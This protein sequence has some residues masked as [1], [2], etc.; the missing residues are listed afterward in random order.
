MRSSWTL[1]ADSGGGT[2]CAGFWQTIRKPWN[3]LN[4]REICVYS[5]LKRISNCMFRNLRA[6]SFMHIQS[7]RYSAD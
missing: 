1:L 5:A 3:G 2:H 6:V 4:L 7:S